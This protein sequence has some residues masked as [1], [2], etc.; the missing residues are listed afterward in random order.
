M[1]L[2]QTLY[3]DQGADFQTGITLY[4]DNGITPLN[5]TGYSFTSQLRKS[6][7]SSTATTFTCTIPLPTTG[8]VVLSLSAAQTGALKSGRYLYDI[9]MV[10]TS[11]FRT[12]PVEGVIIVSPQITQV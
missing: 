6:Y 1:A 8:Q 4:A 12:R 2:V 11:N 9:E 3:I 5:L 7:A 10:D